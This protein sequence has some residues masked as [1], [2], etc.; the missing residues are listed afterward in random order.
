MTKN[1]AAQLQRDWLNACM[2]ADI[3]AVTTD[4]AAKVLSVLYVFGGE[5]EEMTLNVKFTQ[6]VKYIQ[7]RFHIEGGEIPDKKFVLAFQH[8]TKELEKH[9]N[10][11]EWAINLYKDRYGIKL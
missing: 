3:P 10:P 2:A 11:P 5:H 4:T 7:Q 8:Y 9:N 6:E 1:I